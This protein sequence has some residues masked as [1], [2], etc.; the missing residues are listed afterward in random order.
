MN[1]KNQGLIMTVIG[2]VLLFFNA[3]GYIMGW[4]NRSSAL[5]I[6]GLIFVVIG[7]KQAGRH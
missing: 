6:L 1:K 3:I 2:F 5:V 4:E 7:L